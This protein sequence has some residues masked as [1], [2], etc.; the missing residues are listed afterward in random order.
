[1]LLILLVRSNAFPTFTTETI[2]IGKMEIITS[3][4]KVTGKLYEVM[5][6][7]TFYKCNDIVVGGSQNLPLDHEKSIPNTVHGR[8]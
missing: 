8:L 4:H 6:V 5:I 3:T 1:M 7:N 2:F